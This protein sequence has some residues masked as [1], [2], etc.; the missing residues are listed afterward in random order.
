MT[1]LDEY[2]MGIFKKAA[3]L[4]S[5]SKF[6]KIVV[7]ICLPLLILNFNKSTNGDLA[8]YSVLLLLSCAIFII[9]QR[10]LN[11]FNSQI[12]MNLWLSDMVKNPQDFEEYVGKNDIK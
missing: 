11:Y 8:V 9:S 12:G 7:L 1:E 6:S 5:V 2:T 3:I 10:K 4:K